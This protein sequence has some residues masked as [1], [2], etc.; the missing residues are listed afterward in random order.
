MRQDEEI[1]RSPFQATQ[2]VKR[3]FM[4]LAG[5]MLLA[6][7]GF[8]STLPSSPCRAGREQKDEIVKSSGKPVQQD[9]VG[10]AGCPRTRPAKMK[11]R[12]LAAK[13]AKRTGQKDAKAASAAE[14]KQ[15]GSSGGAPV[16]RAK[17]VTEQ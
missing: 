2:V 12:S 10:S 1:P 3:C 13:T 9:P 4:G 6:V 7:A 14:S 8:C 16:A 17:K 15:K 5:A 11:H